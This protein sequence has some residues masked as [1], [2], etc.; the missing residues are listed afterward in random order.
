MNTLSV[1]IAWCNRDELTETLLRNAPV[2]ARAEAEVIVVNCGGDRARLDGLL[3]HI[4]LPN[5]YVVTLDVPFN[6][7]LAL[8]VGVAASEGASLFFLD[9]DVVLPADFF[10]TVLPRLDAHTIVTVDRVV[11][12]SSIEATHEEREGTAIQDIAHQVVLSGPEMQICI[13]TNRVHLGDGSRSG[14]GLILLA[15]EDFIAQD[16]L[17]SDL[18]GWGWEDL[19]LIARLTFARNKNRI[20]AGT[21]L[22]LSHG[23]DV[24]AGGAERK[25]ES[26]QQNF[27]ACVHNY[28]VGYFFGTYD[29]D[30]ET[31]RDRITGKA[32]HVPAQSREPRIHV[33]VIGRNAAPWLPRHFEGLLAQRGTPFRCTWIDDASDDG[34]GAFLETLDV[35][36]H[37]TIVRNEERRGGVRNLEHAIRASEPDEVIV[38]WDA[39]DFFVHDAVVARIALAYRDENVWLTYGSHVVSPSGELWGSAYSRA[40][41]AENRFRDEDWLFLP[42]RTFKASLFHRLTERDLTD[43]DGNP[44]AL[45]WDQALGLPMLELAGAHAMHIRDRLYVYNTH[46]PQSDHNTRAQAQIDAAARVRKRPKRTPLSSL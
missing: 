41:V 38:L 16:G 22:H 40:C 44:W 27:A 19:D 23:D 37:V 30:R 7:A 35:P 39:D 13:E 31:H 46:N 26:E 10:D 5:L 17:N 32:A 11:E 25:R 2:F 20:Q 24:R 43:D 12:S 28:S 29:D 1:I 36:S 34:T 33:V 15:R 18:E 21:V 9:A 42:P 4:A 8:N 6:K 14:P 3:R 45:T